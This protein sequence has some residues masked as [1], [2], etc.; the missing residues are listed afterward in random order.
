LDIQKAKYEFSTEKNQ[1]LI[2]ERSISFEE[3]VAALE[4]GQLLDIINH[5]NSGK[6]PNQKILVVQVNAYV[7]LVPFVEKDKTVLFLKTIFPSR[8]TTKQYIKM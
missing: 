3:V 6:Y 2:N 8:K 1:K 4:N 7:Y 5:P